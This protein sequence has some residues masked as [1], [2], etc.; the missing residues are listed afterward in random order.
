MGG[1]IKVFAKIYISLKITLLNLKKDPI[2][3][4]LVVIFVVVGLLLTLFSFNDDSM[5]GE[6]IKYSSITKIPSVKSTPIFK[7]IKF[8]LI[9]YVP[10][11]NPEEPVFEAKYN[12]GLNTSTSFRNDEQLREDLKSQFEL[13]NQYHTVALPTNKI[14]YSGDGVYPI[15]VGTNV[16]LSNGVKVFVR[17]AYVAKRDIPGKYGIQWGYKLYLVYDFYLG[18][19]KLNL[20][21]FTTPFGVN[22]YNSNN[23]YGTKITFIDK[24]I[25]QSKLYN[26][27]FVSNF[28]ISSCEEIYQKCLSAN[29]ELKYP[30]RNMYCPRMPLEGE[31]SL[32]IGNITYVYELSENYDIP[33]LDK[34]IV[35]CSKLV[36]DKYQINGAPDEWIVQ[37]NPEAGPLV[38]SQFGF[39]TSQDFKSGEGCIPILAHEL[40]HRYT[41]QMSSGLGRFIEG[42]ARYTEDH[43]FD[44]GKDN[45][46][47]GE[48]GWTL[49]N[50][51]FQSQF[52]KGV[53][54]QHF[55]SECGK[56]VSTSHW[57]YNQSSSLAYNLGNVKENYLFNK[58]KT[59]NIE[60]YYSWRID[61]VNYPDSMNVSIYY[62]ELDSG[63][64]GD[65]ILVNDFLVKKGEVYNDPS[66]LTL[67]VVNDYVGMA[68]FPYF[69]VN[70]SCYALNNC[71]DYANL[72]EGYA[73]YFEF[74]ETSFNP[75]EEYD[76]FYG[77]GA[78]F[79]EDVGEQNVIKYLKLQD[80]LI[81]N[82]GGIFYPDYN[83]KK[84]VGESK[85]NQLINKYNFNSFNEVT[86]YV[87]EPWNG[88]DNFDKLVGII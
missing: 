18:N 77:S 22:S 44:L 6:A 41:I 78:C 75:Y 48:K 12:N 23:V 40:T 47:C 51:A 13:K 67:V 27:S 53:C 36:K 10:P 46:I 29:P 74:N 79:W 38:V 85:F 21:P 9:K 86:A 60:T 16:T 62:Q 72:P 42:L 45:I 1:F 8:N 56:D 19:E 24:K 20:L 49:N 11:Q 2:F 15:G 66:G 84:I 35:A 39:K 64:W 87:H 71:Q 59:G 30:C 34:K 7:P 61:K 65:E 33:N 80:N 69:N 32:K 57:S 5:V 50:S 70:Q 52:G 82:G 31:A 54:E 81:K 28:N 26:V 43:Y 88:N 14:E 58:V 76:S 63:S 4:V 37:V 68:L 55:L 83:L 17:N 3:G 25:N 73:P